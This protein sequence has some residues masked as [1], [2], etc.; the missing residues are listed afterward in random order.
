MRDAAR[1]A[2]GDV[3]DVVFVQNRASA[4]TLSGRECDAESVTG[5]SLV[6]DD[7]DVVVFKIQLL[8]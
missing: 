3:D 7:V 6:N 1:V 2:G 5:E 8:R 4:A